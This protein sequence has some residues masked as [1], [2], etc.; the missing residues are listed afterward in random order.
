MKKSGLYN[1][2]FEILEEVSRQQLN[3][4]EVYWIE[5]YKTKEFGLNGTR[6]GS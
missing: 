2:S 3:E 4:R 1:F 6:G 5:L